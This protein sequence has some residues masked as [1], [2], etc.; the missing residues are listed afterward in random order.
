[1]IKALKKFI[2]LSPKKYGII[3]INKRNIDYILE[4]NQRKYY[5]MVD[6]KLITKELANKANIPTPKLLGKIEYISQID[7]IL[8]SLQCPNGFVI[9]PTKGAGGGGILVITKRQGE[10]F[11]KAEGKPLDRQEMKHHI[12]N[13][14]AGLYSLAGARDT[15]MIEERIICHN[16][17]DKISYKGVPDLRIIIYKG[18]PVMAMLRLPTQ[19]SD[20]KANLHS[21]GLG[22]G[23]SMQTGKTTYAMQHGAYINVHPDHGTP[24]ID[25]AIPEWNNIL[26]LAASFKVILPLGYLGIDL[27]IDE[28]KG[29][30]L[31]EAN[32]RPGIAIQ[33][34][35][36][37]G[38]EPRIN[39]IDSLDEMHDT[40]ALRAAF[41]ID[42]FYETIP[43]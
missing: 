17:F 8:N 42:H 12:A 18:Y 38:L 15:A 31:L 1:M 3:G 26:T 30:L 24:L 14:L 34:A 22:L 37:A 27:V 32:A 20:G 29:P 9:K 4:N 33:I 23:L 5:P 16:M 11:F 43:L 36:R 2:N 25:I 40:A 7:G 19:A 35:N 10:S 21:G 13:V 39:I 28:H 41:A 6:D